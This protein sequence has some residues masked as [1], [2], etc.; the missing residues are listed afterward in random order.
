MASKR[1]YIG[2]S[3]GLI[4]A[5]GGVTAVTTDCQ[6]RNVMLAGLPTA[7]YCPVKVSKPLFRSMRKTVM[8]SL[9]RL[10]A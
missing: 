2:Q 7:A 10:Q 8:Q 6:P 4:E 5:G 1:Y 9:R 3:R